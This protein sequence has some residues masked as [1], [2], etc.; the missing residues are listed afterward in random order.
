MR[1]ILSELT[2]ERL[3]QVIE[4]NE[5]TGEFKRV[6][7]GTPAGSVNCDGR[8]WIRV[9]GKRYL[10]HRLA[11]LYVTGAWPADQ[12][13]HRDTDKSNNAWANLRECSYS[14]NKMNISA[15]G[16]N[17]LGLKNIHQIRNG[18]FKVSIG[19]EGVYHQKIFKTIP[20]AKAWADQKRAELHGEFMR[21]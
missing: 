3:K 5:Q 14:Q 11:W 13:D 6:S 15:Q 21:A 4:Y 18:S 10:A 7:D 17:K 19:R 16:N 8:L 2:A 9:D 20:E 12:I 1:P